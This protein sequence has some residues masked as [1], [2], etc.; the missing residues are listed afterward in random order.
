MSDV[1]ELAELQRK[2]WLDADVLPLM[3]SQDYDSIDVAVDRLVQC[4]SPE[5]WEAWLAGVD[6]RHLAP[7]PMAERGVEQEYM[8]HAALRL[9]GAA[10]ETCGVAVALRR[11]TFLRS[12]PHRATGGRF[13]ISLLAGLPRLERA[14]LTCSEL[15]LPETPRTDWLPRLKSVA[16]FLLASVGGEGGVRRLEARLRS[17]LPHVPDVR[18]RVRPWN[19]R[20][21]GSLLGVLG[22]ASSERELAQAGERLVYL[23]QDAPAGAA[24][25]A[26][27]TYAL[28]IVRRRDGVRALGEAASAAEPGAVDAA[29]RALH[30]AVG[31]VQQILDE[32]PGSLIEAVGAWYGV[33]PARM[34]ASLRTEL[35]GCRPGEE[36]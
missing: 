31:L 18:V 23:R 20:P 21:G 26:L 9:I 32:C 8:R 7:T 3:C 36:P 22:S 6:L 10:P 15:R 5:A 34:A 16:V 25:W 19:W 29:R 33:E 27:A 4:N 1:D 11:G 30:E 2:E 35:A 17:V 13:D 14:E 28:A 12:F 24:D